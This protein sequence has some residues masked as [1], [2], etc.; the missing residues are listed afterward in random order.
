MPKNKPVIL[1]V[2]DNADIRKQLKWGLSEDEYELHFAADALEALEIY[3]RFKPWV[4]TLDLG[5]PPYEDDVTEGFRCLEEMMRLGRHAKIVIITGKDEKRNALQAVAMGAYDFYTKP[6]NLDELRVIIARAVHVSGLES[7]R[8]KISRDAAERDHAFG[9]I[10]DCP[11]MQAVINT[12]RKVGPSEVPVLILG[13]S[14]TGKELVARALHASSPRCKG[15]M[16]SINCGAIPENLIEAEFFGHEKGAFT[17]ANSQVKGKVEYAHKGTLFLD[18]IGDLP[19]PLQVKLLRFLQEKVFQRVGGRVDISLDIRVVAATNIQVEKAIR[20]GRFREDL[21]Y[22]LGVVTMQLPP[23]RERGD[24]ILMLA[25]FF[26]ARA[27]DEFGSESAMF[28]PAAREALLLYDWPGNV[29]ELENKVRRAIIMSSTSTITATNLGLT[30]GHDVPDALTEGSTLKHGRE[31]IERRMI[32]QALRTY[33]GNVSK[34]SRS[35][36]I[37]RPTLYEM[38]KKYDIAT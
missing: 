22:R 34:A 38:I 17:G 37:S 32:S 20:D 33:D 26:L 12:V 27:A 7:E 1:I 14:G 4:V 35:L 5:L 19:L 16:V 3:R 2:E 36:G 13:E 10:G 6:I 24:D 31:M 28:S 30:D 9:I 23:L 21:Y 18:E 8:R 25:D 29:R 15:S 11:S